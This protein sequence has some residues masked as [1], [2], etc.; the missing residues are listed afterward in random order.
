MK[1]AKSFF[2][3]IVSHPQADTGKQTKFVIVM[4]GL[5]ARGKSYM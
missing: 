3:N 5:P 4:V 2:D 1:K